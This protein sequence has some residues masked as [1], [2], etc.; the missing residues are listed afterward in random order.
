LKKPQHMLIELPTAD[1]IDRL[2]VTAPKFEVRQLAF[3]LGEE[4]ADLNYTP[5]KGQ[6][7]L[8]IRGKEGTPLVRGRKEK[9]WSLPSGRIAPNE[10]IEK[11]AKRVA[12][13][14]CGIML[15]SFELA[16]MYD[17]VWHY[18]NVSIKR[19]HLVYACLTDDTS[20]SPEKTDE[21]QDARF[22]KEMP[23]TLRKHRIFGYALTDCSTK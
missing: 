23:A 9:D 20:C 2:A 14:S 4:E 19:L 5:C 3:E 17:V 22:F 11:S 12:K 6:M 7:I 8:V 18:S 21:V 10:D 16:G 15:R 13:E 1:E